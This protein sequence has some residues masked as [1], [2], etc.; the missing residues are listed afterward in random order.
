MSFWLQ[1]P[2]ENGAPVTGYTLEMMEDDTFIEVKYKELDIK[3]P[4]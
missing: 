4:L 2:V 1:A 3:L